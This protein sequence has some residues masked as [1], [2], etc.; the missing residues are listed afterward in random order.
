MEPN[1]IHAWL[2]VAEIAQ[3]VF[4]PI[5]SFSRDRIVGR[6]PA[7][8]LQSPK[9]A[10]KELENTLE[11]AQ[12]QLERFE[13]SSSSNISR[14]TFEYRQTQQLARG[15]ATVKIASE[16][17]G[18]D[19]VP[20]TEPDY[21]LYSRI[22]GDVADVSTNQ[23]RIIYAKILAGE[24]KHPGS[25]S[26]KSLSI[27]RD[28]DQ[29]TAELF[30]RFCS[31]SIYM[32]FPNRIRDARV[33]DLGGDVGN[34]SLMRFGLSFDNLTILNEH[35]L[36]LPNDDSYHSIYQMSISDDYH[37]VVRTFT[38]QDRDWMLQPSDRFK[39]KEGF[40]VTGVAMTKAGQELSQ[41]V[42]I[43]PS[44]EYTVALKRFFETNHLRMVEV[45][46]QRV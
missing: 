23:K 45:P 36:I 4:G 28:M 35:G 8:Q 5:F 16:I 12:S 33:V 32:K 27:L 44:E 43:E 38:Y 26:L 40:I 15:I 22:F 9:Q 11:T 25:S 20:D 21:E 3:R 10:V 18:E 6:E 31:L 17:L 2:K 46:K 34:N 14:R 19:Q 30:N 42:D 24:I 41:V 13:E 39:T 29:C 37:S 1:D 7:G